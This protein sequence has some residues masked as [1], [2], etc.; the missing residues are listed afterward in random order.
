MEIVNAGMKAR[1]LS[2]L[3]WPIL[4]TFVSGNPAAAAKDSISAVSSTTREASIMI[5]TISSEQFWGAVSVIAVLG[6]ESATILTENPAGNH[7]NR[8]RINI[9]YRFREPAIR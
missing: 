8:V 3:Q 5:W 7:S 6:W 4:P 2:Q 9:N 1:K